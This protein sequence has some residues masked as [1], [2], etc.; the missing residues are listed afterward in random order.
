ME[1]A[2]RLG[3]PVSDL[4]DDESDEDSDG[5]DD[6]DD[7]DDDVDEE[8]LLRYDYFAFL[9]IYSYIVQG[10]KVRNSDFLTT[11]ESF[12][13]DFQSS[14]IGFLK[15]QVMVTGGHLMRA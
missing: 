14:A 15:H 7:L 10:L 12:Q 5:S 11:T 6:E 1:E 8:E 2:E 4:P 3:I 9:G 13:D